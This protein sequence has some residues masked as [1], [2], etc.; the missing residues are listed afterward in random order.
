MNK[1][2]LPLYEVKE[3][4]LKEFLLELASENDKYQTEYREASARLLQLCH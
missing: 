3:L 4:S 1:N 2:A